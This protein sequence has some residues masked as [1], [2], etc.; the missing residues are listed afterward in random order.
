MDTCQDTAS[1]PRLLF[2]SSD[3]G[4]IVNRLQQNFFCK[5]FE[6]LLEWQRPICTCCQVGVVLSFEVVERDS[7]IVTKVQPFV[8]TQID[9]IEV[10][11]KNIILIL[12]IVLPA[13]VLLAVSMIINFS[14]RRGMGNAY[15]ISPTQRIFTIR[16]AG[17]AV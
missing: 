13:L 14:Q 17:Q 7:A 9:V 10:N 15:T 8:I 16:Q 12:L 3:P 2:E 4:Q 6:T 1:T 5:W 11:M